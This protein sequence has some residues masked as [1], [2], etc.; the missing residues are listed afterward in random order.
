MD[1]WRAL[2][3]ELF[4]QK[5]E[6]EVNA[7]CT[8]QV[9]APIP[10]ADAAFQLNDATR[11]YT[12]NGIFGTVLAASMKGFVETFPKDLA[13]EVFRLEK[14]GGHDALNFSFTI[15]E[16]NPGLFHLH[17]TMDHKTVAPE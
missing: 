17:V 5:I 3:E 10:R 13:R 8:D 1:E 15:N 9:R 14:E 11:G 7:M 6:Q 4:T 16:K 12:T 2:L